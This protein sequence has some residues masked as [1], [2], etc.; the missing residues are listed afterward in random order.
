M[1]IS[2]RQL[3]DFVAVADAGSFTRAATQLRIA[4]PAL[5]HQI[6]RLESELGIRIFERGV[7]GVS[8]SSDGMQLLEHARTTLREYDT[9]LDCAGLLRSRIRR[10]LRVG[11][12]AQGPGDVLPKVVRAF[13]R[14]HPDVE[15][16]LHQFGFEDCFM[17]VTRDLTDVSFTVGPLDD[18]D[19]VGALPLFDEPVVVAMAED[20]PLA[21]RQRLTVEELV[22]EPLFTGEH[23]PGR[24]RDYWDARPHRNGREPVI[25]GRFA[26]HDEWLE[27]VRLGGGVSPCPASTARY[28]PRPGLTFLPLDGMA[29]ATHSILWCKDREDVLIKDF[30]DAAVAIA[31]N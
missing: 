31:G 17:G 16:K 2:I 4:Q 11:F 15:I 26:T 22:R 14:Q 29:P 5:S 13:K 30:V 9:F 25:A 20:H 12:V 3:R 27:A 19:E 24:W 1:G 23:E 21:N 7:R 6:K 18:N 28:Y 10:R 8:L